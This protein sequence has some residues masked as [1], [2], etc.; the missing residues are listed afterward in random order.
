[1][2]NINNYNPN[3]IMLLMNSIEYGWVDKKNNKHFKIDNSFCDNYIL[4]SPNEIIESKIGVCWD[5]VELERYYF[6]NTT[7]KIKTYFLVYYDDDK[8]P[9]HTFLTY[10]ENNK[11]YWFEHSWKKYRGIYEYDS[12][13]SLLTDI[14]NKFITDELNNSYTTS[15]LVIYEYTKPLS[16]I[17]TTDFYA[18]CENGIRIF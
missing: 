10:E 15:N 18:H 3:N 6:S 16:H 14:K 11:F 5:Q 12:L 2:R 1:M 13:T 7:L 9:T 8:C 4:Q 17:D